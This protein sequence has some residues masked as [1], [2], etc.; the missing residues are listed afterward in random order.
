MQKSPV[1]RKANR[2]SHHDS[3]FPLLLTIFHLAVVV[4]RCVVMAK[5]TFGTLQASTGRRNRARDQ[6]CRKRTVKRSG[7]HQ[8]DRQ[9]SPRSKTGASAE[10]FGGEFCGPVA[11]EAWAVRKPPQSITCWTWFDSGIGDSARRNDPHISRMFVSGHEHDHI[12]SGPSVHHLPH[13][14]SHLRLLRRLFGDRRHQALALQ[15]AAQIPQHQQFHLALGLPR[16]GA[17]VRQ[18]HDVVVAQQVRVDFGL[19]LEDVEAGAEDAAGR[20]RGDER[21]FVDDGAAGRVDEH[22]AGFHARELGGG[23]DVAGGGG[24][25]EVEREHV[26]GREQVVEGDVAR[27][28]LL[29]GRQA[30]A[31]VVLDRH[32]EGGGALGDGLAAGGGTGEVSLCFE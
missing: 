29:A 32:A 18:Q 1:A 8:G 11:K 5:R 21:G 22:D 15:R 17:D 23:Q 27:A 16:R 31:V 12:Y 20:E 6:R 4:G 19:A 13:T 10:Q 28:A 25:G 26:R 14:I 9:R 30:V 3:P 7:Q 2:R 24:E